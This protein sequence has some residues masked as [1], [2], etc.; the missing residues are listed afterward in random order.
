MNY[1][2]RILIINSSSI[3]D[4]ILSLPALFAIRNNSPKAYI[5]L[6]GKSE[7]LGLVEN[8]F[9]VD[10]GISIEVNGLS[11]FFIEKDNLPGFLVKYFKSFKKIFTFLNDREGIFLENLKRTGAEEIYFLKEPSPEAFKDHAIKE[12]SK[13]IK[14]L[15]IK[16]NIKKPELILNKHDRN[17]AEYFIKSNLFINQ[18][19]ISIAIHPGSGSKKKNWGFDNFIE[20]SEKLKNEFKC[21]TLLLSGP[22]EGDKFIKEKNGFINITGLSLIELASVL[23]RCSLYIGNDSGITH[24]ASAVGIPVIAIFGPT[25]IDIWKPIG[26]MATIISKKINCSPCSRDKMLYC[27]EQKCLESIDINEVFEGCKRFLIK[28]ERKEVT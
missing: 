22:A 14:P 11:N 18:E 9:Y 16:L 25:N 21:N 28:S 12:Y 19:N 23:E 26:N 24:L 15:G 3:G 7:I 20:L 1:S 5:E 6:M 10:K 2:E 8:R 17:F 13:I 4:F 27:E